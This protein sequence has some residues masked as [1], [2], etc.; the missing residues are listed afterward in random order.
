MGLWRRAFPGPGFR[1]AACIVA[2]TIVLLPIGARGQEDDDVGQQRQQEHDSCVITGLCQPNL[3]A[4][5]ALFRRRPALPLPIA[6]AAGRDGGAGRSAD[7]RHLE[8][9]DQYQTAGDRHLAAQR[10]RGRQLR[11]GDPPP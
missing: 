7:R 11:L 4:R 2:A 8:A 1:R 5:R 9:A 3:S 6:G 10:G